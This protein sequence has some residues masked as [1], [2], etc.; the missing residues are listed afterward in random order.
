MDNGYKHELVELAVENIRKDL[1][2]GDI[3]AI[4]ELLMKIPTDLLEAFCPEEEVE[5]LKAGQRGA[6]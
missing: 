1:M 2:A 6:K 3:T 4:H 5:E